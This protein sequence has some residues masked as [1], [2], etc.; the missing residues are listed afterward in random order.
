M[1]NQ[2]IIEKTFDLQEKL[3]FGGE[4]NAIQQ[5]QFAV[6]VK[7][8]S[9]LLDKVRFVRM[10]TR[11]ETIDKMHISE[12]ITESIDENATSAN[13][14]QGRFNAVD[15]NAEKTRTAWD[16]TSEAARNNIEGSR[17]EDTLMEALTDR[18][19]TDFELLA[20]Q[21]DVTLG[22]ATAEE[23]LRNR[24]DGWDLLSDSSHIVD[25]AG[26]PVTFDVFT[27][28]WRALPAQFRSDIGLRWILSDVIANDWTNDL[29]ARLTNAGDAG[30]AGMPLKPLGRTMLVVPLVPS[31]KQL[32]LITGVPAEVVGTEFG[33]FQIETGTNDTLII[34]INAAG[35]RNVV[36]PAGVFETVVIAN[37]INAVL[38][39]NA[40]PATVSDD[41]QGRLLIR[42]NDPGVAESIDID[43]GGNAQATLGLAV[44]VV[45]GTDAPNAGI[46]REGSFIWFTNP[47]NFVFGLVDG[48]RIFSRFNP[49]FD[50]QETRIFN[51]VAVQIENIDAVAKATNIRRK[52]L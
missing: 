21:G 29:A 32:T 8:F 52:P 27:K 30:I 14:A 22:N 23:R 37:F 18:M 12:P 7:K 50:R 3:V 11:R 45:T 43:A 35:D 41:G 25:I 49:D 31:D 42:T 40:D 2:E 34:N 39:A 51:E 10:R 6:L 20:I 47:E 19:A 1:D 28:L 13:L 33:P 5:E 44:A 24:L 15:L 17:F 36:F 9:I 16:I 38:I 48:T 26:Q 46:V 4:L